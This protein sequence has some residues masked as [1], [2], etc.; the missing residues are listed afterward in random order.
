M[1]AVPFDGNKDVAGTKMLK[2]FEKIKHELNSYGFIVK[3]STWFWDDY[4]YFCFFVNKKLN[5]Y[6]KVYGPPLIHKQHV[7]VFR[8]KYSK[9]KLG[10]GK[11]RVY[12][13]KPRKF[14]DAT[15]F[16]K[17]LIKDEYVKNRVK[18]IS[19]N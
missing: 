19:L 15:K 9:Y 2:A 4:G 1:K 17:N 5:K 16:I 6:E 8:N 10:E 3:K 13:V 11:G 7:A 14:T 18:K 12:V